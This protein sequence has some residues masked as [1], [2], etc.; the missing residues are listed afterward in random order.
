MQKN[1][2]D[3]EVESIMSM[4]QCVKVC[5]TLC[6]SSVPSGGEA[7]RDGWMQTTTSWSQGPGADGERGGAQ[8]GTQVGGASG[9][10]R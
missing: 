5:L 9:G 8:G 2:G 3:Q 1:L 6:V 4:I 10:G 7:L